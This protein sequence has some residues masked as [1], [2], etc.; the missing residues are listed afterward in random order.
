MFLAEKRLGQMGQENCGA[1]GVWL[2]VE[3]MSI[4][5]DW[6]LLVEAFHLGEQ[7]GLEL[8]KPGR[9]CRAPRGQ[10]LEL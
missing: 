1:R 6:P 2:E 10:V 9:D 7:F 4:T 5:P 3:A 8:L